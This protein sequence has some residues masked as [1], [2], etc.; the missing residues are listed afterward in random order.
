MLNSYAAAI[1]GPYL[2]AE[3][4]WAKSDLAAVQILGLVAI[5]TFPFVGRLADVV[6]AR[7]TALVGII[8]S[9]IVFFAFSRVTSIGMFAGIFAIQVFFLTTTTPPIYC[10]V[11]VQCFKQARGLALA[12]AASGP[13]LVAAVGGPLLNNLVVAQ[14]WKAGYLALMV[15][16]LV[17][18]L[19]AFLLMPAEL[20]D[21]AKPKRKAKPMRKSPVRE[22]YTLIL[23]NPA[24]W[25]LAISMMLCNLPQAIIL[26]QLNLIIAEHGVVGR[27]ASIMVSAYAMGMLA[28]RVISG[29]ALDRFPSRLVATFGLLIS[30]F[31]LVAMGIGGGSI[32]GL[33]IA[34]LGVGLSFGAES[35]ILAYLIYRHFG[36]HTFSTVFGLLSSVISISAMLGALSMSIVLHLT[37]SYK[38]FLM[39]TGFGVL[40]GGL[41]LLLL[42]SH[43]VG[44]EEVEEGAE[45]G[46]VAMQER[47]A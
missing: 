13:P 29:L 7:R 8:A 14:G 15:F 36:V 30:A 37:D 16:S 10:R 45:I 3:F 34:V 44:G 38:P 39:A 4:G 20:R 17:A 46:A 41:L 43:G 28:G 33:A 32:V 22:D 31:G 40:I 18:G 6:G 12:V 25:V 2:V 27:S 26:T 9:P 11:I 5:F 42:P 23:R 47:T 19:A 1:M 21:G 35:D 24:F